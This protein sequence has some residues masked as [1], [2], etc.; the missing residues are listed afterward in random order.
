MENKR[1]RSTRENRSGREGLGEIS[2]QAKYPA[3]EN[4]GMY[5]EDH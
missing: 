1:K 5:T 4:S 3:T 2:K